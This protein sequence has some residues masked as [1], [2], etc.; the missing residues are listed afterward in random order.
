MIH[1]DFH[2]GNIIVEEE[3]H[4][5]KC[6]ITDLGLC[7][8][9]NEINGSNLYGIIPYMA[10]ELLSKKENEIAPYSEKSDV[11]S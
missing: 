5:I 1:C 9:V 7:R 6:H 3:S 11:Y 4:G 8:P 10:P 2:V